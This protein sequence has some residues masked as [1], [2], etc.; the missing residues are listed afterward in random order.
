MNFHV[1]TAAPSLAQSV[2][3]SAADLAAL[4]AAS[5]DPL[6]SDN[7][8]TLAR[9]SATLPE[10][11]LG[12][13]VALN[14]YFYDAQRF[15]FQ[16]NGMDRNPWDSAVQFKDELISKTFAA[17]SGFT[18]SYKFTIEGSV[19]RNLAFVIERPRLGSR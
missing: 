17:G 9:I 11:A 3:T 5:A 19:P 6:D 14:V 7:A 16:K 2:A 8:Q 12:D 10:L 18:A 15:A 13:G 4:V 1:Y